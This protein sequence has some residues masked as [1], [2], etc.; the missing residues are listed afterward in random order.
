MIVAIDGPA[1]S[2]KST[3]ARIVARDRG[4]TYLDTG[5]MYRAL[6]WLALERGVDLD[7]EI[8]L[9][10]IAARE[11]VSFGRADDGSQSVFIA[12]TDV[13][14]AIRMPRVDAAVS[15]VARVPAVRDQMVDQQRKIAGGSDVVA[16]G[17]DIGTVVFP[18]AEVKVFLTASPET[19]AHRRAAQN[20]ALDCPDSEAVDEASVLASILRRDEIDS[21]RSASPLRPAEDAVRIDSSSCDVE[22]VVARVYALID[23]ASKGEV[24]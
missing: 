10:Q 7:D 8:A 12:G 21:N 22:D 1:G 18:Q 9:A 4:F 19:R 14:R 16:E 15:C 24:R 6:A 3:V 2:G 11:P 5:A 17:R 23:S 13:T 20:G